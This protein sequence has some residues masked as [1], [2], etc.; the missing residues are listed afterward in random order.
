M[1]KLTGALLVIG[2]IGFFVIMVGGMFYSA[3]QDSITVIGEGIVVD[4]KFIPASSN[5]AKDVWMILL[6]DGK[7][8]EVK[9]TA[10][11]LAQLGDYV[12]IFANQ[13]LKVIT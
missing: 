5:F 9:E 3:Y 1:S 4:F 11:N 7:W 13:T 2:L 12:K 6:D 8:Y 10:Y